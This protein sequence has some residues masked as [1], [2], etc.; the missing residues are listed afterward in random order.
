[1]DIRVLSVRQ[2]WAS[3]LLS[4]VKRYECRSWRPSR[5]GLLL[6]HASSRKANGISTWRSERQFQEAL[7]D[8][9]L[10]DERRW[11]FS[12]IIGAAEITRIWEPNRR[13]ARFTKRD[14]YLTD[15][16]YAWE[17]GRRWPF[18][19]PIDCK[20]KL[21]LWRPEPAIQA[22]VD[23]EIAALRIPIDQTCA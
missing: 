10:Q 17:V 2:P 3:L 23:R 14:T 21:N 1:M 8:A 19:K 5:P 15:D 22:A 13:P 12:A 4:G 16:G 9:G 20:G 18:A 7:R 11:P 6:L